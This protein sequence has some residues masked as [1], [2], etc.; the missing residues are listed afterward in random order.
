MMTDPIWVI[1]EI[2]KLLEKTLGATIKTKAKRL[3]I[4]QRATLIGL[5]W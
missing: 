2:E 1:I 5:N 4:T 3:Q